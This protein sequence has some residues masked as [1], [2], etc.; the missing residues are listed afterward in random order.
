MAVAC[1]VAELA[2]LATLLNE[3]GNVASDAVIDAAAVGLLTA[4]AVACACN[5]VTP[6]TTGFDVA[7]EIAEVMSEF[8]PTPPPDNMPCAAIMVVGVMAI[9]F[10]LSI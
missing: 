1:V 2:E 3:L 9:L 5:E 8:T 4:S 7:A 10:P 6:P